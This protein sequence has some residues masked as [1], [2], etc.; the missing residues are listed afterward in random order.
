MTAQRPLGMFLYGWKV[1]VRPKVRE[2]DTR[3]SIP[4]FPGGHN[5]E[6]PGADLKPTATNQSEDVQDYEIVSGGETE[7][8]KL[9]TSL[10]TKGGGNNDILL[11]QTNDG[12]LTTR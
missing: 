3:L 11:S 7:N 9:N 5:H 4:S 10:N 6:R 12:V 8:G 2:V 1:P